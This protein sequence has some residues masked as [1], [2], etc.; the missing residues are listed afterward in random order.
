MAAFMPAFY[1]AFTCM[2]PAPRGTTCAIS[3]R[4]AAR[5]S[6]G[7]RDGSH[8]LT[9]RAAFELSLATT[10]TT[11]WKNILVPHDFSPCAERALDVA[12]ELAAVNGAAIAILHVSSLPANLSGDT[13]LQPAGEETTLRVDEYTT[14]AAIKQ[15]EAIAEPLRRER[16]AVITRAV[17]GDVTEEILAATRALNAD[18]LVVGTH[19][20]TGLA[21]LLLGSVAEK[22]VRHAPVPVVTVRSR[23]PE[24]QPTDEERA[25]ED[26]LTG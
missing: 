10:T 13:R 26:E 18:V 24:A 21:H 8:V 9:T 3:T 25:V 4:D 11:M 15:L 12:A 22:L 17:T 7:L 2:G 1:R 5:E 23:A 20:R 16:I 14:R 6:F 19:G